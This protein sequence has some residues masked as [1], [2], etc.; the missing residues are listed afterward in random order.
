MQKTKVVHITVVH[1]RYDSRIFYKECL[2]LC[3]AGYDVSLIVADGL[4]D[5]EKEGVKIIDIGKAEASRIKRMILT[6]R[7]AVKVALELN[8]DIYHFHDPDLLSA[9]LK[10][11][12]KG[13]VI[14]DSHEDFP[15]LMLQRDYIPTFARRI[16][17]ITARSIE[18]YSAKRLSGI[19]CATETIRDKFLKYRIK[20]TEVVKNYPVL[21]LTE[22]TSQHTDNEEKIACYV[23][24]LT[25]VRGVKEMI[26]S[27]KKAGVKLLLAGEFDNNEFFN[28]T[29]A[30]PEWGNV[31]FVGYIPTAEVGERIY[32]RASIG[33]V[34]LHKEP[35]H[36][37]SIPIKQFEYMQAGLPVIASKEVLFCKQVTEEENC[38]LVVDPLNVEETAQAIRTIIDNPEKAKQMSA[39]A[40]KASADKYNWSSQE[41]LLIDFYK[42]LID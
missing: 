39:N 10:L 37:H 33:L 7:K 11:L 9:S 35:N 29:K 6:T 34:L 21:A 12:K 3:K 18:R 42:R 1:R 4:G 20:S 36:T 8:A 38:G 24:G 28:Q 16:L 13:K 41:K 27:C 31:E 22:N 2:S 17:F 25:E 14:F 30:M 23:G 32:K 26:L 15:A 40:I 5:E 19:V